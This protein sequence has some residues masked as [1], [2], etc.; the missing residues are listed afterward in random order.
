[1]R[2]LALAI[3]IAT[4]VAIVPAVARAQASTRS[5]YT[6]AN[7]TLRASPATTG[8]KLLVINVGTTL[9]VGTCVN[10][11]CTV[12]GP[13]QRGFV[14]ERFLSAAPIPGGTRDVRPSA[15]SGKGYINSRG[16]FVP[17]PRR[18]EDGRQPAG[19]TAQCRDGTFSFSQSRR[20]TCSHHGGVARWLY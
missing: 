10:G 6:T 4:A 16:A 7:V 14:A 5:V 20:G 8:A 2:R 12:L 1:M 18:S 9:T 3:V 15:A 17:S 13:S 11:W 19:A